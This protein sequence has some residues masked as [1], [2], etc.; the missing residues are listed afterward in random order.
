MSAYY[1][2]PAGSNS[3]VSS[4]D[5]TGAAAAAAAT[6]AAQAGMGRNSNGYGGG[7]PNSPGPMQHHHQTPM[8]QQHHQHSSP[9]NALVRANGHYGL[10]G[11]YGD[12]RY[13]NI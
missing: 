7:S 8:H 1:A 6:L 2:S 11:Y 3:L 13:V 4:Y 5:P 9:S 12:S 10:G